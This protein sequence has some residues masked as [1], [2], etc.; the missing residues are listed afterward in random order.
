MLLGDQ[1]EMLNKDGINIVSGRP[2]STQ[3]QFS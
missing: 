1:G 2:K 3:D